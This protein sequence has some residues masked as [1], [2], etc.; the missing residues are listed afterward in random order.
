MTRHRIEV[1][2]YA[3]GGAVLGLFYYQL[4]GAMSGPVFLAV[5][6][7]YLVAVRIVG[8]LVAKRLAKATPTGEAIGDA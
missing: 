3:V 1:I 6:I 5:V 4:K 2:A 8:Y 7:A